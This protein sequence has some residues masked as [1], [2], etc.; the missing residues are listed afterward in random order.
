LGFVN[1][2]PEKRDYSLRNFPPDILTALGLPIVVTALLASWVLSIHGVAWI[3]A[4][5]VSLSGALFG[6]VLLFVAKLPLYRQGRFFTF[7]IQALPVTSHRF[8]RWGCRCSLLGIIAM[9]V[10]WMASTLWR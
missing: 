3:W 7:G 4:A 1:S 2:P 9:F 10:L 6:A 8:Y 5:G